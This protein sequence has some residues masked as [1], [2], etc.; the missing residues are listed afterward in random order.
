MGQRARPV[1]DRRARS[2]LTL[3]LA[4]AGVVVL[5]DQLTKWWAL[6]HLSDGHVDHVIGTLQ[7]NLAFNTGAAFSFGSGRNLGPAVAVLALVVVGY[8]VVSGQASRRRLGSITAG[9]IAGG[10]LGNLI[11]RAFRADPGDGFFG[12]SVVDFIDLQW[13]PIF[14]IADASIVVGAIV[15]VLL[16]LRQEPAGGDGP[17]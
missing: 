14:N 6:R 16:G 13:W 2:S 10:A 4:T 8:L 3:L 5:L 7:F 1:Q 17:A 12:G 15:F 11:D 9:M